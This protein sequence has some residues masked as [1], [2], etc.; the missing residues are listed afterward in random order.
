MRAGSSHS[1]FLQFEL[2][3]SA[4][5]SALSRAASMETLTYY[6]LRPSA[7]DTPGYCYGMARAPLAGSEDLPIKK[8]LSGRWRDADDYEVDLA[9]TRVEKRVVTEAE[10]SV[11]SEPMWGYLCLARIPVTVREDGIM[12]LWSVT[13]RWRSR[14]SARYTSFSAMDRNPYHSMS[15]P[16]MNYPWRAMQ[17]GRVYT[18]QCVT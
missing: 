13:R 11:A 5:P 9:A 3:R 8:A 18:A 16:L 7:F 17:C 2:N 15:Q 4:S 14:R 12:G 1:S 6:Y 10:A